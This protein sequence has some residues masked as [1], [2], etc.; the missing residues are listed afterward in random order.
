MPHIARL[1]LTFVDFDLEISACFYRTDA[2]GDSIF[3]RERSVSAGAGSAACSNL[4][5]ALTFNARSDFH[6]PD[7]SLVFLHSR[8]CLVAFDWRAMDLLIRSL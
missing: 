2:S 4:D 6:S 7:W 3:V 8:L 1:S 5:R